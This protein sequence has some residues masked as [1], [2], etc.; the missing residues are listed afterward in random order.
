MTGVQTCALPIFFDPVVRLVAGLG[1]YRC[2]L[3][4]S[5]RYCFSDSADLAL[6]SGRFCL[7]VDC[8]RFV[9]SSVLVG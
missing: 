4:L 9:S 2:L 3:N 7:A 1:F 5:I 6:F 8:F